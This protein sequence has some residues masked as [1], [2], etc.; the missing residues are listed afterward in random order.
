MSPKSLHAFGQRAAGLSRAEKIGVASGRGLVARKLTILPDLARASDEGKTVVWAV[1]AEEAENRV[2]LLLIDEPGHQVAQPHPV[3][4]QIDLTGDL[5]LQNRNF[6]LGGQFNAGELGG[7]DHVLD[8]KS[9][10]LGPTEDFGGG[11]QISE[12]TEPAAGIEGGAEESLKFLGVHV[13]L[14]WSKDSD[15]M[16][17]GAVSTVAV[18]GPARTR[19]SISFNG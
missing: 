1:P 8:A 18:S 9:Q 19:L 3:A 14:S 13:R 11:K 2:R 5:H 15:R 10:R 17:W 6:A 4:L 12:Q 16:I 7:R